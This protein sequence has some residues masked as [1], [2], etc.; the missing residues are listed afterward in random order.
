V[1]R[2]P[3][4]FLCRWRNRGQAEQQRATPKNCRHGCLRYSESP[5]G[6]DSLLQRGQPDRDIP[7]GPDGKHGQLTVLRKAALAPAIR[8]CARHERERVEALPLAHARGYVG[9]EVDGGG[10]WAP[11]RLRPD[12]PELAPGDVYWRAELPRPDRS[13]RP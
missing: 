10:S 13:A 4:A 11:M 5:A 1:A 9:D 6:R 7:A 12:A 3:L 2:T 8:R